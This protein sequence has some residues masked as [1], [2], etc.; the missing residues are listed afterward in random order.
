MILKCTCDG[1]NGYASQWQEKAGQGRAGQG[2]AVEMR[3]NQCCRGRCR[4]Y[5]ERSEL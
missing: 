3:V 4:E 2:R 5:M 1:V